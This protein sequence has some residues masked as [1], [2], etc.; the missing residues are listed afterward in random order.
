VNTHPRPTAAT[1]LF[2]LV[3]CAVACAGPRALPPPSTAPA[4]APVANAGS[5]RDA[6]T[7]LFAGGRGLYLVTRTQTGDDEVRRFPGHFIERGDDTVWVSDVIVAHGA[8][9]MLSDDLALRDDGGLLVFGE[10]SS[11]RARDLPPDEPHVGVIQVVG[12][13]GGYVSARMRDGVLR[14]VA[15][16]GDHWIDLTTPPTTALQIAGGENLCAILPTSRVRCWRSHALVNRQRVREE[17]AQALGPDPHVADVDALA[18]SD[19]G[20]LVTGPLTCVI[21]RAGTVA[22]ARE[23]HNAAGFVFEAVR[24]NGDLAPARSVAVG[25]SDVCTLGRDERVR[26]AWGPDVDAP[27][28][29]LGVDVTLREVPSLRGAAEVVLDG[30]LGCAR[31]PSDEVRCWGRPMRDDGVEFRRTP[32]PIEGIDAAQAIAVDGPNACAVQRGQLLCWGTP[33][34]NGGAPARNLVSAAPLR[35]SFRAAVTSLSMGG[36]GTCVT[37][38]DGSAWCRSDDRDGP[39]DELTRPDPSRRL[40]S[41]AVVDDGVGV[42]ALDQDDRAWCVRGDRQDPFQRTPSLD[43]YARLYGNDYR[44]WSLQRDGTVRCFGEHMRHARGSHCAPAGARDVIGFL[45]DCAIDR[46]G[47]AHCTPDGPSSY[48]YPAPGLERGSTLTAALGGGLRGVAGLGP[49][50]CLLGVNGRLA[51]ASVG[52]LGEHGAGRIDA[53]AL[54]PDLTDV[55]EVRGNGLLTCARRRDG[56]VFCWGINAAGSLSRAEAGRSPRLVP[57][58]R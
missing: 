48:G 37:L 39:P 17:H 18:V 53:V 45:D 33:W 27:A 36:W 3:A 1:H 56:R 58:P 22:C 38:L 51:C 25:R 19:A 50:Q 46:D 28:G 14:F 23:V 41:I 4:P 20:S 52:L 8:A 32:T 11:V 55:E 34:Y 6:T 54:L 42:C 26:C 47:R 57:F 10:H 2:P 29:P 7:S 5:S 49:H 12:L 16:G 9:R 24:L 15:P 35:V 30:P 31:W 40:R 13:A 21:G 44:T 43:R